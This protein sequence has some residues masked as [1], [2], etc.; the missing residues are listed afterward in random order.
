[1]RVL[2]VSTERP[3]DPAIFDSW[4]APLL[5]DG[6]DV[7]YAAPFADSGV[8][9]QDGLTG[10]DLPTGRGEFAVRKVA[11]SILAHRGREADLVLVS[12]E[13]L[14]D[15]APADVHIMVT[16]SSGQLRSQVDGRAGSSA[17][18]SATG[19]AGEGRDPTATPPRSR[20][21]T[22]SVDLRAGVAIR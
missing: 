14:A 6:W 21:T 2:V 22:P 8:K 3:D 13:R 4:V 11:R 9:P 20:G 16:Q 1:M 17:T 12:S 5:R 18:P 10:L 15:L 19:S 7:L